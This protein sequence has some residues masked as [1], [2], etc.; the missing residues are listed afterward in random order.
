[1]AAG[2]ELKV[3]LVLL[4]VAKKGFIS[5]VTPVEGASVSI[6]GEAVGVSPLPSTSATSSSPSP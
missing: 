5:V 4:P 1:M 2:S 3:E 6:D